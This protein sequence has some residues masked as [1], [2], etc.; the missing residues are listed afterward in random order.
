MNDLP[1]AALPPHRTVHV[2]K[3]IRATAIEMAASLYSDVMRDNRIYAEWKRVCPEL[4]PTM[5][6]AMFLELMWPKLIPKA[7]A[8]LA[9]MLGGNHS[10]ELKQTIYAALIDDNGLVVGRNR[11][12]RRAERR[13]LRLQ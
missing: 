1:K 7:R 11:H 6:E 3:L 2:H 12:A 4:T 13:Q 10:E 5:C 9:Q 8:T